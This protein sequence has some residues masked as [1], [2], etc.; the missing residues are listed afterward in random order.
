MRTAIPLHPLA[1]RE[2]AFWPESRLILH[3]G[4]R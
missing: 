1:R 3:G 2:A 4:P